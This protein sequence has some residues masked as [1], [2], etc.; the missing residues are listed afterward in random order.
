MLDV[1]TRQRLCIALIKSALRDKDYYWLTSDAGQYICNELNINA[2]ELIYSFK[3]YYSNKHI[4]PL[5][6]DKIIKRLFI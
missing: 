6:I 4:R 1:I 2:D 5:S 3:R